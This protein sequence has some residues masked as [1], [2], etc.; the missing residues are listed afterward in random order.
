LFT[1]Y[2]IVTV[3]VVELY[4]NVTVE[5]VPTL[6]R[7]STARATTAYATPEVRLPEASGKV[8]AEVPLAVTNVSLVALKEVPFHQHW[9]TV[10][11]TPTL[12]LDK[13]EPEFEDAVPLIVPVQSAP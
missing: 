8:Q 10:S 2:V 7:P 5:L 9:V 13:L 6:P 1:G 11:S 12:V 4:V 3:G